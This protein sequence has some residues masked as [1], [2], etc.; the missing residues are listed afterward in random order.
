MAQSGGTSVADIVVGNTDSTGA[1]ILTVYAKVSCKY[2]VYR[3]HER[4]VVHFADDQAA[5]DSQRAALAQL[6]ALRGQI[7]GLINGWRTSP[8][9]RG[10][11]RATAFDRRVADALGVALQNTPSAVEDAKAMLAAIKE[12]IFGVR[13]ARARVYYGVGAAAAAL[14]LILLACLFTWKFYDSN[15]YAY[16]PDG[17]LLWLAL[18]AGALGAFFSIAVRLQTR[19]ILTDLQKRETISDALTRVAIGAIA[20]LVLVTVFQTRLVT[21][22]LGNIAIAAARPDSWLTPAFVA[23]LAGFSE[24]LVP[25]LLDRGSVAPGRGRGAGTD[26]LAGSEANPVRAPVTILAPAGP[27]PASC[28]A[29]PGGGAGEPPRPDDDVDGGVEGVELSADDITRDVELPA[30]QGGV[31]EPP[32][33]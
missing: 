8:R 14:I 13:T 11:C 19:A 27:G 30:A 7:N 17:R 32:S 16:S 31:E 21:V 28:G 5:G 20:G 29:P 9:S 26:P 18:G 15:I 4:V 25:G 10:Y 6:N 3:T 12:D 23:F 1:T 24:M 2:A 33:A 22:S